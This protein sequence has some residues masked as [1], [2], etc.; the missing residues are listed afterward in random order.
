MSRKI[1][2]AQ[3]KTGGILHIKALLSTDKEG[4]VNFN[5]LAEKT[6]EQF[7]R[8][9]DLPDSNEVMIAYFTSGTTGMPKMVAHDYFYPLCHLTTAKFWHDLDENDLHLTVADTGWAKTSW[10]KIYGQWICE[11]AVFV[12]DYDKKFTPSDFFELIDRYKI[13]SFC[14][15]PT[16]YRFLIKEDFSRFSLKSLIKSTIAGEPLNPEIY[17]RWLK[18]TGLKL[19]EGYGQTECTILIATNRWME[20]KPGS[21]GKPMPLTN[22]DVYDGNGCICEPGEAGELCMPVPDVKNRPIGLFMGYYRDEKLTEQVLYNG[23][24]HTGDTVWKDEDGYIWFKGRAD[25]II[26]SSGYRIGPFEVE[27]ALME[28]PSVLETAITGV[29]D[30]DRGFNVKATIVLAKG[31]Q[32]SEKLKKELQDHVK[33]VTAPYKYPRIIEFVDQLPKTISG[34]IRRVEIRETDVVK[35]EKHVDEKMR[36]ISARIRETRE[37]AGYGAEDVAK[38]LNV[39]VDTY[40]KYESEGE[41]IPIS[42]LYHMA[43]LFGVD[44]SE[45]LTGRAPH[46]DTYC[47]VP[48]NKGVKVDRYPGYNFSGLAY[49]FMNKLM[50]PMIV[51]VDPRE[52]DPELVTHSGQELNYVIEGSIIVLFDDKRIVLEEGDFIYFN[53]AHPH[54]QKAQGGKTAKFLTVIAER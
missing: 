44:M 42:A 24:Y 28:H 18:A 3:K 43:N 1:D 51:S 46:I 34:K 53:P 40:K 27:S 20:P 37:I 47:V 10:G 7:E 52:G 4:Y 35:G 38:E 15:P 13:T 19:R 9:S 17:Y 36:E 54:G 12:Y 2:E 50:E 23:I 31:Y 33:R 5:Q 29:P 49:K 8:P 32:P 30:P 6:S 16:I 11:A 41:N 14:A 48:K 26:K 21:M 39:T 22:C 45:L 25:D